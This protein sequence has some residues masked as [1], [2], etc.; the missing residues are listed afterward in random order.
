MQ[1]TRSCIDT[2]T[3]TSEWLKGGVFVDTIATPTP[4]SRL[5]PA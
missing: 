3:G 5:Q 1:I 4:P 2:A